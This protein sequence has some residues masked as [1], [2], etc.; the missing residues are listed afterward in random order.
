[1]SYDVISERQFVDS[2]KWLIVA[3]I[4]LLPSTLWLVR[5]GT[6]NIHLGKDS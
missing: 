3:D 4:W 1:M 5:A 2:K 6:E